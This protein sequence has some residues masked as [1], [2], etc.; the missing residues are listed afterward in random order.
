MKRRRYWMAGVPVFIA[1]FLT[2]CNLDGSQQ[3]GNSDSNG[4]PVALDVLVAVGDT[5][6]AANALYFGDG[7]GGFTVADLAS[8]E[9]QAGGVALAD[10]D[11]DGN[12]DAFVP[13]NGK[14]VINSGNGATASPLLPQPTSMGA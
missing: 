6:G 7:A 1:V 12:L 5:D 3:S 10:F 8:D 11:G 13:D 2:G 14:N 9:L 4:N